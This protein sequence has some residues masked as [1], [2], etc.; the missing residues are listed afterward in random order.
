MRAVQEGEVDPVGARAPVRV[1]IRLISAT[2]RDLLQLVKDGRF[3]EDLFYRLNVFP[4][5]VPPLRDRMED[6]PRAGRA[7]H[8]P[9][10]AAR[11]AQA[12]SARSAH[13]ALAMLVAYDWPGN[14]RQLENA[15]FRAM[16]LCEGN[17]LTADDFPQIRAQVEG[18][19]LVGYPVPRPA[20]PAIAA[21]SAAAL[22]APRDGSRAPAGC[23]PSSGCSGLWTSAAMCAVYPKSS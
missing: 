14:V 7:L 12:R 16:V 11:G 1:D 2:H 10:R 15:V 13:D 8:G 23:R 3:R 22:E 6:I 4:I 9:G 17:T 5:F 19:A 21:A 20:A 18:I